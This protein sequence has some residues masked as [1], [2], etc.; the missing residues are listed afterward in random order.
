MEIIEFKNEVYPKF[1]SLGNASQFAIPYAKY[2]CKGF[3][4][5]IGFN[6]EEWKLPNSI[7]FDII[8][9]NGYDANILPD[10]KVDYIYSSHC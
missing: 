10:E 6:K 3:G 9:N 4:Y 1:Q 2:F 8:L 7:G 5:D